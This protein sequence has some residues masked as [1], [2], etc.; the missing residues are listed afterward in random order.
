MQAQQRR[1][2]HSR[3]ISLGN[4]PHRTP[5]IV[6][7]RQHIAQHFRIKTVCLHSQ[8]IKNHMMLW[9]SPPLSAI[10]LDVHY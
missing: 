7:A 5:G 10:A 4:I 1:K 9:P 6:A 3:K 2:Y 8:R